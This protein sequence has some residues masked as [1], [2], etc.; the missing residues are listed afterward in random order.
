MP[1]RANCSEDQSDTDQ[2]EHSA[3]KK[4]AFSDTA[5]ICLRHVLPSLKQRFWLVSS[6]CFPSVIGSVSLHMAA[7]DSVRR[8]WRIGTE[9]C[10]RL[11]DC[12]QGPIRRAS[13]PPKA[14]PVPDHTIPS[15]LR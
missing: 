10:R 6:S 4:I 8:E 9:E 11:A 13:P 3:D 5:H 12:T 2:C 15:P 7:F 14:W 1:V